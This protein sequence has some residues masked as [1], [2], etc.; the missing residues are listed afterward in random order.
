M[1]FCGVLIFALLGV[2]SAAE[3]YR[4]IGQTLARVGTLIGD[5]ENISREGVEEYLPRTLGSWTAKGDVRVYLSETLGDYLGGASQT[6]RECGCRRLAVREYVAGVDE[7]RVELYDMCTRRRA[8]GIWSV[9]RPED[10]QVLPVGAGC[11]LSSN[12][13]DFWKENVY[14]RIVS[15]KPADAGVL[16]ELGR[17][18]TAR[19]PGEARAPSFLK[20]FP[21]EG[22]RLVRYFATNIY[23]IAY[24][25]NGLELAYKANGKDLRFLIAELSNDKEAKRSFEDY[26]EFMVPRE[27]IEQADLRLGDRSLSFDTKCYGKGIVFRAG[28]YFGLFLGTD[29]SD[30]IRPILDGF[31]ERVR[32]SAR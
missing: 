32:A 12:A 15:A 30:E 23:G 2:L 22:L 18:I 20:Y 6:F 13:G 27:Q 5:D 19:I 7:V 28:R 8:F 3:N 4:S 11:F 1:Y 24:L 16:E 14:G 17:A 29:K 10:S 31:L 21:T 26:L 25:R 9:Q